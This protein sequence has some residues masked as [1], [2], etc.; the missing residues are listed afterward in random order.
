M[1]T[2][3][4]LKDYIMLRVQEL[5]VAERTSIKEVLNTVILAGLDAPNTVKAEPWVC[6]THDVGTARLDYT[7]AWDLIDTLESNAVAEKMSLRK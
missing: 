4:D 2:T 7:K 6:T 5:A 3:C 1:R